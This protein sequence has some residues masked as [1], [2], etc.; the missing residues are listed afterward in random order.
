MQKI[1]IRLEIVMDIGKYR[2]QKYPIS[3]TIKMGHKLT[4]I[5]N[6]QIGLR[7]SNERAFIL[8]TPRSRKRRFRLVYFR[9]QARNCVQISQ[10]DLR[11]GDSHFCL[12]IVLKDKHCGV[13]I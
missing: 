7:Q 1:D 2:K 11:I 12:G 8:W 9:I 10:F 6:S 13:C 5:M 3:L 4:F